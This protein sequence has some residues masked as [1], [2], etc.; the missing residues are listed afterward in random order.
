[1]KLDACTWAIIWTVFGVLL[2]WLIDGITRGLRLYRD[3]KRLISE[4][5][6]IIRYCKRRH[7][8]NDSGTFTSV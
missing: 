8:E 5:D 7:Y 6:K 2:A 1:M 3:R 4:L